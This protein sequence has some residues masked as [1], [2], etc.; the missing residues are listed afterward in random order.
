MKHITKLEIYEWSRRLELINYGLSVGNHNSITIDI[1]QNSY[2]S[3][4]LGYTPRYEDM[5]T[6][7][8]YNLL[9][10]IRYDFSFSICE[11][12]LEEFEDIY[13]DISHRDISNVFKFQSSSGSKEELIKASKKYKLKKSEHKLRNKKYIRFD[14]VFNDS[15]LE[16]LIKISYIKDSLS[17]FGK[18][19]GHDDKGDEILKLKYGKGDIVSLDENPS[20][21]YII[22]CYDYIQDIQNP[23]SYNINYGYSIIENPKLIAIEYGEIFYS[24]GKNIISNRSERLSSLLK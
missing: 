16:I 11:S 13:N 12:M 15:I 6:H 4:M 9:K 23:H 21:D 8:Y 1:V 22:M 2:A 14:Y 24:N 20:G 5:N 19:W 3:S 7:P 18:I 10:P 17:I